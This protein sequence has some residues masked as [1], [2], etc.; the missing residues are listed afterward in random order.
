[1]LKLDRDAASSVF[2]DGTANGVLLLRQCM[3]CGHWNSPETMLC[4]ACHTDELEWKESSGRGVVES[5]AVVRPRH[6]KGLPMT[7]GIVELDEGPW[8]RGQ[9]RIR[10]LQALRRGMRIITSFDAADGGESLPVFEV[11]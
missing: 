11:L 4:S 5:W 7:V 8:M 3:R 10:E 1:M 6:E 2:F 9:L